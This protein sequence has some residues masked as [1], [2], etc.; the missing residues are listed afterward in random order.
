MESIKELNL[1]ALPREIEEAKG[2]M[3]KVFSI[4]YNNFSSEVESKNNKNNKNN[5]SKYTLKAAPSHICMFI[6]LDGK[7]LKFQIRL[8]QIVALPNREIIIVIGQSPDSLWLDRIKKSENLKGVDATNY[9][10]EIAAALG[11]KWLHVYDAASILCGDPNDNDA[12]G[13][14]L[15][16]YRAL[17]SQ[18]NVSPSWYQNV[19]IKHGFSGISRIDKVYN[20]AESINRL[21]QLKIDELLRYYETMKSFIESGEATQYIILS[22]I[23]SS[24]EIS[25]FKTEFIDDKRQK[26]VRQLGEIVNILKATTSE[27]LVDFLKTPTLSC[28][29]KA[30]I[31]RSFP[32]QAD[33][34]IMIPNILFNKDGKK[35]SEFPYI[36]DSLIVADSSKIP[37]VKFVGGKTRT[38]KS[39]TGGYRKKNRTMCKRKEEI[40]K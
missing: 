15:S 26:I 22:F 23:E 35:I 33:L 34:N 12:G 28:M 6:M 4:I 18:S 11:A 32:G 20:Y 21:R 5:N 37:S 31:L 7:K 30:Y 3:P 36:V 17:T 1:L 25:D 8:N 27:S 2:N 39:N 19:A 38:K 13:Y 9:A 24:G 14:P 29:D 16:F 10:Y 40:F